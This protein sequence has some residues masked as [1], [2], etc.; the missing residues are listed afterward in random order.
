MLENK[1]AEARKMMERFIKLTEEQQ[2]TL[3]I[4]AMGFNALNNSKKYPA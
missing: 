4:M 1:E 3:L 2:K